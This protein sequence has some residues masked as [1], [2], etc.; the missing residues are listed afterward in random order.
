LAWEPPGETRATIF[1]RYARLFAVVATITL[2]FTIAQTTGSLK[3]DHTYDTYV[4]NPN[5]RLLSFSEM[6]IPF[7]VLAL[8][9]FAMSVWLF[10]LS[11]G[12]PHADRPA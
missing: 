7:T 12:Q 3:Y 10:K 8:L 4:R 5:W 2:A 9:Y 11:A 1:R 6:G